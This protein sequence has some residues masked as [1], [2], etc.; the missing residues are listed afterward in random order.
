MYKYV[1]RR[2]WWDYRLKK[3]IRFGLRHHQ[4]RN[5]KPEPKHRAAH[6]PTH[7]DHGAS[8]LRGPCAPP[9][10][11]MGL[12]VGDD[13]AVLRISVLLPTTTSVPAGP[14]EIRVPDTVMTPPGVSV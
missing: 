5:S 9:M 2:S 3:D 14:S 10:N 4:I 8:L 11:A 13:V 7:R 12:V 1:H 6:Q